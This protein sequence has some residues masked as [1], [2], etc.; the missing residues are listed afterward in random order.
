MFS[1]FDKGER[2]GKVSYKEQR[3]RE[4]GRGDRKMEGSCWQKCFHDAPNLKENRFWL[5]RIGITH[6]APAHTLTNTQL[7][8]VRDRSKE[9][10]MRRQRGE[11]CDGEWKWQRVLER[12]QKPGGGSLH[13][14]DSGWKSNPPEEKGD[15]SAA[16]GNGQGNEAERRRWRVNMTEKYKKCVCEGHSGGEQWQ[17]MDKSLGR[18]CPLEASINGRLSGQIWSGLVGK[19]ADKQLSSTLFYGLV[20]ANVVVAGILCTARD[21]AAFLPNKTVV[22]VAFFCT[23]CSKSRLDEHMSCIN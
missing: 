10:R 2:K 9:A 14:C 22:A 12:W 13:A 21:W 6:E 15:D 23:K 11:G 1:W 20:P 5:Q 4:E 19:S 17:K 16:K 18:L 8:P 7:C 3:R